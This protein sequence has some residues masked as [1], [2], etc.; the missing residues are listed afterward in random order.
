MKALV[1]HGPRDLRVEDR[2]IPEPGPGEVLL[3]V[4][5]CGICGTDLRIHGGGHSAYPDGTVRVPGHEIAGEIA[6]TGDG[7][8][9]EPGARMFLAPNLEIGAFG[10]TR[11]GGMAQYV[12]APAGN[13]LALPA[14]ADPAAMSV[15]EPL[16]CV[17]RGQRATR[18]G[19]GD[20]ALIFGAG[21]IGLLHALVARSL[22]AA[23]V[24]VSEPSAD[25][26]ARVLEFDPAITVVDPQAQDLR[27]VVGARGADVIITAAP[28]PA[29]QTQAVELAA[30]GGRI[31]FFGGLAK[32]RSVVALDTNLI[33]YRELLV[34]GTTANDLSDCRRAVALV[35]EGRIDPGPFVSERF[36]L[37]QADAAFAAAAGGSA[38]KVVF[39]PFQ[40]QPC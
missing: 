39:E 6:A 9:L 31:N 14:D 25:R 1:Y 36:G 19:E 10:I 13:L 15:I 24:I 27:D 38:L 8:E 34:T 22:G 18:T 40:E 16:A 5:A 37:E 12:A 30:Q 28:V 33:H 3:K 17:V 35:A 4:L 11:D 23:Q 7:V 20:V 21:P 2:P 29:V 32:D 26:R